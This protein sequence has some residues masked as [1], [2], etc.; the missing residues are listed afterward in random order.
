MTTTCLKT[1]VGGKQG[2]AP[3]KI[4]SLQQSTFFVSVEFHGDHKAVTKMR[5]N[6]ATLSLGDITR[7]TTAVSVCT[8]SNTLKWMN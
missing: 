8:I 6:L 4:L 5:C 2:H 7:L 3:C 1:V